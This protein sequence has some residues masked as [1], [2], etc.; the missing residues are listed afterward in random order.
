[1]SKIY[2]LSYY[3]Y[4]LIVQYILKKIKYLNVFLYNMRNLHITFIDVLLILPY[5]AKQSARKIINSF[6]FSCTLST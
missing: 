1:M 5:R 3:T 2:N 6:I 4:I